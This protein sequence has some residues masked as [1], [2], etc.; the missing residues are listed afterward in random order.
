VRAGG[1]GGFVGGAE[2]DDQLVAVDAAAHAS[3]DDGCEAAE[4]L[5]LVHGVSAGRIV[6]MRVVSF[7]S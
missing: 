7:S 3:G 6:R 4:D 2:A 1:S 5:L